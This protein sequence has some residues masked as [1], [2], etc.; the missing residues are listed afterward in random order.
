[1]CAQFAV[2]SPGVAAGTDPGSLIAKAR[3]LLAEAGEALRNAREDDSRLLALSRA[4]GAQE[5]ALTALRAGLRGLAAAERAATRRLDEQAVPL[6]KLLSALQSLSRAPASALLAVR[7]GP[8]D[9]SRA[10]MVLAALAPEL[11]RR[12]AALERD[13]D[14]LRHLRAQQESTR[15]EA[16]SALAGLQALRA[17]AVEAAGRRSSAGGTGTAEMRRQARTAAQGARDLASLAAGLKAARVDLPPGAS[18]AEAKGTLSPPVAGDVAARFGEPDPW[19]RPG[20]GWTFET[21]ALAQV[22]AP[23]DA[24]VRYA[25]PL[26]D[27]GEVMVLEPEAGYLVV[28][29]GLGQAGRESGETVLAGERLGDMGGPVPAKEE[30]LLDAI[31]EGGQIG[32]KKLYVE[33]RRSGE[34]LDP[35]DW[36]D[37]TTSEASR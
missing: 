12:T 28:L 16:R 35:A 11:D 6:A 17:A 26:I 24:T 14:G 31:T 23:W 5:A 18:F 13:L 22:T 19:G 1:L 9:S 34:P 20:R 15:A 37:M 10:A 21:T 33:I 7:G 29:A 8:L 4:V 36:F 25:G 2:G 27:Y 30:F 3:T 32:R